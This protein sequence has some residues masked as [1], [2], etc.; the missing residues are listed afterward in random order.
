MN[1]T[2]AASGALT[3]SDPVDSTADSEIDENHGNGDHDNNGSG[4]RIRKGE[5]SRMRIL[6]AAARLLSCRGYAATTLTDIAAAAEMQAGSLYYHFDSKDAIVE[7]VLRV[8]IDHARDAIDASLAA[9]GPDAQGS[10][11]LAETIVA[12]VNCIVAESSFTVA[13]IRC[14]NESPP[15][16]REQLTSALRDFADL[17]V[18]LLAEGQ[19]DGSLRD[20]TSPKVLARLMISGLNSLASWYRPGGELRLDDLARQFAAM[21]LHGLHPTTDA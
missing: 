2:D 19:A 7:E 10:E 6:D 13:N 11:R 18:G 21:V 4:R 17:W 16:T 5:R 20:D 14:Y 15:H 8:G 3:E 1:S 9:L 12:Y